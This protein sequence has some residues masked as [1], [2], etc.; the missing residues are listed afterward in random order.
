M[1]FKAEKKRYARDSVSANSCFI[2][3][4]DRLSEFAGSASLFRL[5]ALTPVE[6][7]DF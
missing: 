7:L 3:T 2:S 1:V 5:Y 4:Y 6:M